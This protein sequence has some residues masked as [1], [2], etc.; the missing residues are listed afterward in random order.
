MLTSTEMP[1]VHLDEKGRA[2]ID[3]TSIK[4]VEVV[5][6]HLAYGWTPEEMH[7]QH[8]HLSVAQLYAAMAY[9][10]E[11]R[12]TIDA[13]IAESVRRAEEASTAAQPSALQRSELE[14]RLARE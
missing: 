11:H 5:M 2:W 9:Y 12:A 6:D 4:V 10:H 1:H 14:A 13:Q 3:E 8:P 7:L